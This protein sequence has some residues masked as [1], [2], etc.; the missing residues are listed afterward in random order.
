[1]TRILINES[2]RDAM[3]GIENFIP[4]TVKA[5]YINEV[6]KIG[7]DVV[8]F[9]SFVSPKLVPQMRD[10][11]EVLKLLD[12]TSTSS[13]LSVLV[14]NKTG[15]L[16]ASTYN[17]I[18][19]LG[20]PFSSS[21][22]FLKLNLNSNIEQAFKT[23]NEINEVCAN[24]NKI[25]NIYFSMAFGN[26]Y[27]DEWSIELITH[28]LSILYHS[29]IRNITLSDTLGI[30]GEE[31]IGMVFNKAITT[32][33]EI[34]FGL[35]LHTKL[36]HWSEKINAAFLNGCRNF[37][38]VINGLGGCPMA[39]PG[40]VGNLDTSLLVNFFTKRKVSLNINLQKLDLLVNKLPLF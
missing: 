31:R 11:A 12:L 21:E 36:D 29:G 18:A 22:T 17:E 9:G 40:L 23:I 3:Q 35:H 20:F 25:L 1:M 37:D 4:S 38:G 32:F 10:T 5:L 13:K 8:D 16:Q 7:F 2:P 39:G 34:S 24:T 26:P 14:G 28:Y 6:L 19:I 30:A 27:G 15:A 33:P